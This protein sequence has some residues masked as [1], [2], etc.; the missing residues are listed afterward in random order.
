MT[1]KPCAR[2][3]AGRTGYPIVDAGM[4]QLWHTGWMHNRVRMVV[5]SFLVKHLLLRLARGRGLVLGHAGR[6]RSGQQSGEL[7]VGRRLRRRRGALF[8]HLQSG[9]AGR[10]VRS[11]TAATCARTCRSLPDLPNDFIHKPWE[12]PPLVLHGAGVKLGETYP[13][14]IVD[15]TAARKRA[16]AAFVRRLKNSPSASALIR[17]RLV[18]AML[19]Y[20]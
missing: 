6:C 15:H 8:P 20:S 12:A 4:R 7:A 2:G 5:A 9:L 3:S 13:L 1:R 19:S 14:P 10:E 17:N 16:L 18:T 11:R